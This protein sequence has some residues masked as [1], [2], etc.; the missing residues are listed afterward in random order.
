[1]NYR[2]LHNKKMELSKKVGNLIINRLYNLE[3]KVQELSKIIGK[4]AGVAPS[5]LV[6]NVGKIRR[7]YFL[8]QL[9]GET[10]KI[11][12]LYRVSIIL[13]ALGI[14][15]DHEVISEMK[16]FYDEFIY[17]PSVKAVN[18]KLR[19]YGMSW[20]FEPLEVRV[21][22]IVPALNKLNQKDRALVEKIIYNLAKNYEDKTK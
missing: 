3:I 6:Q 8:T 20:N 1:M 4:S 17:P 16:S 10:T 12:R 18:V 5:T 13:D 7:G 9:G 11:K 22:D 14:K 21:S 19:K 2:E 15:E